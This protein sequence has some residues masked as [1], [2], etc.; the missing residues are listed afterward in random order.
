MHDTGH[1][2]HRKR[3]LFREVNERIRDVS[4]E[5]GDPPS[6]HLLCECTNLD[7]LRRLVVPVDAYEHVRLADDRFLVVPG[8]EQSAD[9]LGKPLPAFG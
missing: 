7:C 4:R 5:F 6:Y 1:R 3:A 8:H 2:G 9:E